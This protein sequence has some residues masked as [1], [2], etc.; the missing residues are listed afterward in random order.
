MALTLD[1][2]QRLEDVGLI[3]FFDQNRAAWKGLAKR[4]YDFLKADFPAGSTITK[5]KSG[6]ESAK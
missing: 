4:T 6:K 1:V 3:T 5:T 2:E